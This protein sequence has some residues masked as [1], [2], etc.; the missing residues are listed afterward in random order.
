MPRGP[1]PD[2]TRSSQILSRAT[3][4]LNN[5]HPGA[6]PCP[7]SSAPAQPR[8]PPWPGW[9]VGLILFPHGAQHVLG[10]FGGYGFQGTLGWMTGTLGFPA[11]L[12]ALALVTE[13]RRSGRARARPR[14]PR[15]GARGHRPHARGGQHPSVERLLH[16]LVRRPPRRQRGVRVPPPRDRAGRGRRTGGQRCLV[17]GSCDPCRKLETVCRLRR[18]ADAGLGALRGHNRPRCCGGATTRASRSVLHPVRQLPASHRLSALWH[19]EPGTCPTVGPARKSRADRDAHGGQPNAHHCRHYRRRRPGRC[20]DRL[21]PQAAPRLSTARVPPW[22]IRLPGPWRQ[23]VIVRDSLRAEAQLTPAQVRRPLEQY[24]GRYSA[25]RVLV[26]RISRAVLRESRR[27]QVPPS[28]I[29]AV[30]VT[31]NTD[32]HA[33]RPKA[34][35]EPRV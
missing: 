27:Q 18:G 5:Y 9:R 23:A 10:W 1:D 33:P 20:D 31:E 4:G 19:G 6:A 16:E 12:A 24:L 7:P 11:P 2:G 17:A 32:P 21:G 25:D 35:S 8:C 29:A 3:I 14:R 15:R 26:R 34:R 28:L 22:S 13:T 30:L